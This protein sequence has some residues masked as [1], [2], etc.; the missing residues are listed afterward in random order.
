MENPP[1]KPLPDP[2]PL[3][4]EFPTSN[5]VYRSSAEHRTIELTPPQGRQPRAQTIRGVGI[6]M[7]NFPPR[8]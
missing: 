7:M 6:G 1:L 2:I 5:A 4:I 8:R 3:K